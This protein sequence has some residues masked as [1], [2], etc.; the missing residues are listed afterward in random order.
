MDVR[1][2]LAKTA[3]RLTSLGILCLCVP[4]YQNYQYYVTTCTPVTLE[5]YNFAQIELSVN[6]CE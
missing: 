6:F 4:V 3:Q 2:H 5:Q 1:S